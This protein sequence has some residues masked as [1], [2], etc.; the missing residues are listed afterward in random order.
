MYLI[1]FHHDPWIILWENSENVEHAIPPGVKE[2]EKT[3]MDP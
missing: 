1:F 3:I 2:S